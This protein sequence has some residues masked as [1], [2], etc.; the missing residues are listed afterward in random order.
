VLDAVTATGGRIVHLSPPG[1][2]LVAVADPAALQQVLGKVVENAV[3]YS[4]P[5]AQVVLAARRNPRSV[6]IEVRDEGPGLPGSVDVFAPFTRG[7]GAVGHGH[8]LGLY[9][10]RELTRAMGGDVTA[11]PGRP[12][13]TVVR[14]H[15]PAA[16]AWRRS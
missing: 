15:L 16:Q 12:T 8:G 7:A 10:A 2:D 4:P 11:H 14:V 6:V 3:A 5:T 1:A 9:V 13:G